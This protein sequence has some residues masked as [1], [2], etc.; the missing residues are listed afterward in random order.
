VTASLGVALASEETLPN[1]LLRDADAA[2]YRAKE[3]GRARVEMFD[4]QSRRRAV[5]SLETESELH[6]ALGRGEFELHYQP[7]VELR[8]AGRVTGFEALA[9]WQHP[10]RGLI[11]P[12]EFIP[13]AEESG[14]IVPIGLWVLETACAQAVTW[15]ANSHPRRPP[16]SMSVNLAPRQLV[17]P[18]F[19][20]DLA[21]ILDRSGIVPGAVVLELTESAL[22]ND[23]S[24]VGTMLVAIRAL[25]VQIA[26]DDFGTGYSSLARL[27]RFPVRSLKIDQSFVRGLGVDPDDTSIVTAIISL[28]HSL[29]LAVVA[30]GIE[31]E[32]QHAVLRTLGCD[33]GQGF[34]FG[35]PKPASILGD[36][37]ADDLSPWYP[38]HSS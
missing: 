2:M 33:Y 24:S 20:H 15:Q 36:H 21:A 28:A 3:L 25:G 13:L 30:E 17:E 16:L 18:S 26:V 37:P 29:G 9:R 34:L 14:L 10:T 6:H 31:T 4:G 38:Q 7:I 23:A 22:M 11:F 27:K 12:K 5:G 32:Q 8:R 35:R 19:L 1:E